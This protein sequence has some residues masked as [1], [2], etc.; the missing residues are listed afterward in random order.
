MYLP[1]DVAFDGEHYISCVGSLGAWGWNGV[2]YA[3]GACAVRAGYVG[4][5]ASGRGWPC[6]DGAS[7]VVGGDGAYS[8]SEC[9]AE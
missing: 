7:A 6:C 3:V 5:F 2:G 8:T 1:Y 9:L 4:N